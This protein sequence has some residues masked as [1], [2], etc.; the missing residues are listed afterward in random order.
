MFIHNIFC[1]CFAT[2]QDNNG[3]HANAATSPK[4]AVDTVSKITYLERELAEALEANHMYKAQLKRLVLEIFSYTL[5]SIYL[6]YH[7]YPAN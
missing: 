5:Q 7:L 2:F 4:I 3:E 6:L 1:P